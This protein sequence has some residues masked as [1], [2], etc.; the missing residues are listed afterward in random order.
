MLIHIWIRSLEVTSIQ[1]G[2]RALSGFPTR[3]HADSLYSEI[4]VLAQVMKVSSED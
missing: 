1:L 4:A 2:K 3:T